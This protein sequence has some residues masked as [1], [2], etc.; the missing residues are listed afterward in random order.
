[1]MK[2]LAL[3]VAAS[4]SA[5]QD[6]AVLVREG[7]SPQIAVDSRGTVRMVFGR[8]DTIFAVASPAGRPVFGPPAVVGVVPDMH[9]GNTRGP[10][11]ASSRSRTVILAADSKGTLTTFELDHGN[12]RWTRRDRPLN[13]AVGSAPEGLATIA[14]DSDDNFYAVWLDLREGRQNNIYFTRVPLAGEKAVPNQ[15]IYVSP[16]G[17]V[18]EC[19]RPSVAVSGRR[20]AVMFRNWVGGARDLYV[21][22]SSD[23]G[24]SFSTASKLGQGSWKLDACPMDGGALSLASNGDVLTVWRRDLSIFTATA[25]GAE[26]RVA[27]GKSPMMDRRNGQTYLVWQDGTSIMLRR[28]GVAD[29]PV[30]E[31]R[32]PQVKVLAD[33]T[34]LVAW[35]RAGNLYYRAF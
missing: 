10:T 25:S 3:L 28:P 11:I 15:R 33:G 34:V 13:D 9:L 17:H 1:M 20:V 21:M 23:R 31:G 8:K 29:Q 5:A 24:K 4:S 18:C 12:G 22:R 30:G 2:L 14:A 32:L 16:D 27:T 35:E 26:T 6:S 19:C 7:S